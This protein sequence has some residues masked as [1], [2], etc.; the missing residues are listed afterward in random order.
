MANCV[1]FH[2]NLRVQTE[3]TYRFEIAYAI[4]IFF[5]HPPNTGCTQNA[6]V[7]VA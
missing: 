2:E 3:E 5:K 6:I 7:F 4:A 1:H